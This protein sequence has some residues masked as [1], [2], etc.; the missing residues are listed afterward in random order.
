MSV[1]MYAVIIAS[2]SW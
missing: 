1:Y 2:G